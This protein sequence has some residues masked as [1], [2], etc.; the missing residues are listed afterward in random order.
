M[1][2]EPRYMTGFREIGLV[3]HYQALVFIQTYML[4]GNI[5]ASDAAPI[6]RIIG[7]WMSVQK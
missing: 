3:G 6:D 7:I 1:D 2:T 5:D 4:C